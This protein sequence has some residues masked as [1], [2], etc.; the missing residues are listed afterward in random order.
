[1]AGIIPAYA[2]STHRRTWTRPRARDHPRVC[3]EH[4]TRTSTRSRSAGSSP[5]MRGAPP[6]VG[7]EDEAGGIIPAYAGSTLTGCDTPCELGDHPRVCGEH[8]AL[9]WI[10]SAAG[11]SSPRM[12]GAH[13]HPQR[14]RGRGGIIPAYAGSTSRCRARRLRCR[15]H[16]RVCG[17]HISTSGPPQPWPGSSPRMRGAPAATGL[18]GPRDGIIPAYAGSTILQCSYMHVHKDH[19]RVC[20]EHSSGGAGCPVLLGSSPR[21]RGAQNYDRPSDDQLGIIP[22]YAGSTR[23][24]TTAP[25]WRWN[26]P[27]VCGEHQPELAKMSPDFGI[28]PAYAGSTSSRMSSSLVFEDHPRVCGEHPA[29][30]GAT[31]RRT[32]SSP[33]MRGARHS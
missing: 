19:P 25:T 17:E 22:A 14:L 29:T 21:M 18:Y 7:C 27:R 24:T 12:R 1:M 23:S 16:P 4:S 9:G 28:I 32:G 5:R 11:G 20:G 15:D 13:H 3:G 6:L 8:P 26:H 33:R 2:G 10:A 30:T 31:T